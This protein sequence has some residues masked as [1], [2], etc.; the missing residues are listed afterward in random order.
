[1]AR[2]PE[3]DFWK[4]V[5]RM[6]WGHAVRI[7]ASDGDVPAGTPDTVLSIGYRGGFIELKVWPDEASPKQIAWHID[8]MTGGAYAMVL[9]ELPDG[10]V[11]LGSAEH[12]NQ[13]VVKGL[14]PVGMDL[15]RA[16][17]MIESALTGGTRNGMVGRSAKGRS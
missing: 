2:G 13:W 4:K 14:A 11:W 7:E 5:R 17:R 15:H 9:A 12:W 10:S 16:L 1:M 3:G 8:A 6:W